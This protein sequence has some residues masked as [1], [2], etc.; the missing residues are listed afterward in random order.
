MVLHR[1]PLNHGMPIHEYV[2]VGLYKGGRQVLCGVDGHHIYIPHSLNSHLPPIKL[3]P[4]KCTKHAVQTCWDRACQKEL[5]QAWNMTAH[6][7]VQCIRNEAEGRLWA[8]KQY[9]I[10]P[11]CRKYRSSSSCAAPSACFC[12]TCCRSLTEAAILHKVAKADA[13]TKHKHK[14]FALLSIR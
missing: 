8:I 5:K 14:S 9:D 2:G 6:F 11:A 7:G 4:V 3:D 10:K 1:L 12:F 13:P